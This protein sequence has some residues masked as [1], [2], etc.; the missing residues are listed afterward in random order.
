MLII[1]VGPQKPLV[2]CGNCGRKIERSTSNLPDIDK[3]SKCLAELIE[4]LKL[5]NDMFAER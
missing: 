4:C 1:Q 5:L 2:Y 3:C